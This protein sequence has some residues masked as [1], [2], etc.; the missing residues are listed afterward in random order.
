MSVTAADH[1]RIG[2]V[3][4]TDIVRVPPLSAD[5]CRVLAAPHR[6]A[7]AEFGE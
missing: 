6:L 1:D 5:K 4:L 7:Y 3:R 2:L